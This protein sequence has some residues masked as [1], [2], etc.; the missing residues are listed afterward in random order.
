MGTVTRSRRSAPLSLRVF[1]WLA[2]MLLAS[3]AAADA[4]LEYAVKAAYLTKFPFY[5]DWPAGSFSAPNSPVVLCVVG[6]DPFGPLLDEAAAGQQVQGHPLVVR[7]LKSPSRESGCH[8]AFITSDVRS[9]AFQHSS[10][11]V[12]TDAGGAGNGIINFVLKDNRVRFIIDEE[13]AVQSGLTVSS[14]LL[15]V[16]LAVKA[17]T[18]R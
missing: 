5:I 9:D 2:A 10:T 8:E 6:E 3:P 15:S 12:V 14:R 17:K 18:A 1:A 16:A 13:A 4:P 7:R 11:L